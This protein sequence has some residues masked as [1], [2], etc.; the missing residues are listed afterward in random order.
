MGPRM[1]FFVFALFAM[2]SGKYLPTSFKIK[3]VCNT[4]EQR[5]FTF[6]GRSPPLWAKCHT[7]EH[8]YCTKP[9][10]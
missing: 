10:N 6:L 1:W 2:A 7:F 9:S 5:N 3:I 4:D 8:H